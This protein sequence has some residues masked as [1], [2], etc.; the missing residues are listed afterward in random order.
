MPGVKTEIFENF[1]DY[2]YYAKTL[3]E[4]QREVIYTSLS[5]EQKK[6]LEKSYDNGGWH[7][8]IA[9]NK[10][11]D[12]VDKIKKEDNYDLLAIRSKV[13]S[14]RSVYLPRKFWRKVMSSLSEY[15]E[16]DTY[17]IT[18]GMKAIIQDANKEVILL[19]PQGHVEK[20]GK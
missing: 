13:I 16:E 11:N 1:L 8:V 12:L 17:F 7:D 6:K 9:R 4:N 19:V 18:G 14:G 2:W 5:P 15:K 3:S 10:L 20:N